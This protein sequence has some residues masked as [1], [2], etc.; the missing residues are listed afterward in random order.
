[1]FAFPDMMYL[2]AHELPGLRAGRLSPAFGF[3]GLQN[4]FFLGHDFLPQL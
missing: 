1:M 2:L 4:G 3:L